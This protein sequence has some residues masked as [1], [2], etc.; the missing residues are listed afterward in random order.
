M[1][2]VA[3]ATVCTSLMSRS[4]RA[5]SWRAATDFFR[6]L[7]RKYAAQK[8]V[9]TIGAYVTPD[10]VEQLFETGAV[11]LEPDVVSIDVDGQDYWIWEAIESYRPRV[12]VIEYNSRLDPQ[13]RLVQPNDPQRPWD[14]TDYFGASL[15]ALRALGERKGYRLVHTELSGINAFFVRADLA[16]DS[17]PEP[18]EVAIRGTPN[19]FQSGYHH[20]V[21]SPGRRYLDLDSGELVEPEL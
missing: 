12:L 4:G 20:P 11:P 19:Y 14:G 8:R 21:A 16:A 15:G 17:F 6:L 10:N 3:K 13:R 1:S 18:D 7:E 2:L 9:R 5:S